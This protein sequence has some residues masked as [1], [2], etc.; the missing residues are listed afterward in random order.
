MGILSLSTLFADTLK[1]G[2]VLPDVKS[3]DD[4][5]QEV[6]LSNFSDAEWLLVYFYPKVD[7]PGCTKQACSLRDSYEKLTDEGVVVIGVSADSVED[8][9]AFKKKYDL[10]FTLLAD[11]EGDLI[12]SFG[13]PQIPVLGYASR[14]A[15]LFQKGKLVWKD[16][17]ASTKTQALDILRQIKRRK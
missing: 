6:K 8:Q 2:S 3:V 11:T 13:V 15:Y 10:P 9:A 17:K 1:I 16:E 14:Q 5:E 4:N 12:Q 7:T